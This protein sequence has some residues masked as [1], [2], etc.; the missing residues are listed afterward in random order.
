[1]MITDDESGGMSKE[2]IK[3]YFVYCSLLSPVGTK[4]TLDLDHYCWTQA[5]LQT[6]FF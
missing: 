6:K 3:G 4:E 1:M 2:V 5:R